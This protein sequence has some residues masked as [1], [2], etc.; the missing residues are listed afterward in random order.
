[1]SKPQRKTVIK[2]RLEFGVPCKPDDLQSVQTATAKV[3]Q[4]KRSIT[5]QGYPLL[6]CKTELAQIIVGGDENPA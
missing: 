1:M 2:V 6:N 3:D 4:F 5:E